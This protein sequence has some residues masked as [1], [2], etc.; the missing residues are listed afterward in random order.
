MHVYLLNM[1]TVLS[2]DAHIELKQV[3][4]IMGYDTES[5]IEKTIL[6]TLLKGH[7]AK[8]LYHSVL[9]D[10][11][12]NRTRLQLLTNLY[13]VLST[14]E[15]TDKRIDEEADKC[16]RFYDIIRSLNPSTRDITTKSLYYDLPQ[17][18]ILITWFRRY[19][20]IQHV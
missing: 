19:S 9:K 13:N 1:S 11:N 4:D 18:E 6:Y 12:I 17:T 15:L 20:T 5:L 14:C 16:N 3:E 7:D 2:N 8:C 10:M